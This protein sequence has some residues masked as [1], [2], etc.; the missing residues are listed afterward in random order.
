VLQNGKSLHSIMVC[1][2]EF[3]LNINSNND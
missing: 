3:S 2:F 1:G